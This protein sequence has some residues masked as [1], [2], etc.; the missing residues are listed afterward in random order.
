MNVALTDLIRNADEYLYLISPY[1]K[2]H[3]RIKDQLKLK[4]ALPTLQIVIVFGKSEPGQSNRISDDDLALLKQFPDIEIRYEKNLHAKYYA[5]ED[6]ALITSLN[7]YDF[8]QNNNIE[9]GI[10]MET[11]SSIVGKITNWSK[12]SELEGEAFGFF[13]EVIENAQLLYKRSPVFE[14][15]FLCLN[16]KYIKS[17]VEVDEL[18]RFF[19]KQPENNQNFSGF[20]SYNKQPSAQPFYN[21]KPQTGYCIRTGKE[22]PFNPEKPYCAEAYRTWAQFG[23]EDYPERFCH[24]TGKESN[25]KTTLRNP[26]LSSRW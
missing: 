6:G 26:I 14:E 13:S 24:K 16:K 17:E 15:S 7:L 20:K 25:G 8:S 22:I 23:N 12:D 21:N 9:A 10:W 2:L 18:D 5:S 3:S 4:K 1:I 11:P 19:N